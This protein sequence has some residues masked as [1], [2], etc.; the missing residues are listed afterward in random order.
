M[1]GMLSEFGQSLWIDNLTRE[2]LDSGELRRWVG[3]YGVTGLT[4]NPHTFSVAISR[5]RAYDGAV[6]RAL[7]GGASTARLYEEL[8]IAEV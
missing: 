7:E 5:S 4:S 6:A 8:V 1:S 2:M 3:E